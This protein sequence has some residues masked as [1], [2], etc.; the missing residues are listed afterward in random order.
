MGAG[1]SIDGMLDDL[2]TKGNSAFKAQ[3]YSEALVCYSAAID[4]AEKADCSDPNV[5]AALYSNRAAALL[6][7]HQNDAALADAQ[8]AIAYRPAW[9]KPYLRA[10]RALLALARVDAAREMLKKALAVAAALGTVG[11]A[12][13]NLLLRELDALNGATGSSFQT[14][15]D[16]QP[17]SAMVA[18]SP[19][20]LLTW[21]C[22]ES[23]CLGHGDMRDKSTP[24]AVSALRGRH[25]RDVGCGMLHT[26]V[27][28]SAGDVLAWGCDEQ[29]Q[30]G[31]ATTSGIQDD[32]SM[33]SAVLEPAPI[34]RLVAEGV[35]ATA[36]ACGAAHSVLL[37]ECANG[38]CVF[39]WGCGGHGQLGHGDFE[40]CVAPRR[41][42]LSVDGDDCALPIG[43]AA[44]IAHSALCCASDGGAR[45]F[46]MWGWNAQG[47]L[48]LGV[49][50]NVASPRRAQ[51]GE[52]GPQISSQR[53]ERASC[54]ACGGGHS[55]V[56]VDG[57]LFTAGSGACGQ[58]GHGQ[59]RDER[60]FRRVAFDDDEV[61]VGSVAFVACGEE[62]TCVV[63]STH[64]VFSMGLNNVGQLGLGLSMV[65]INR[66][67]PTLVQELDGKQTELL[68]CS[69]SQAVA[70]T[71]DGG[72]YAWGVA[73]NEVALANT[74]S[75]VVRAVPAAVGSLRRKKV[76][77][78]ECGRKHFAL[79][80]VSTYGPHCQL[81]WCGSK[82]NHRAALAHGVNDGADGV[83]ENGVAVRSATAGQL[84]RFQ[85]QCCDAFGT[86]CEHGGD[87]VV[88]T[89][90][91][92]TGIP[93]KTG[94]HG[95]M[96]T[97]EDHLDGTYSGTFT[98]TMVGVHELSVTVGE[99]NVS[100]SPLAIDVAA[101]V[102]HAPSCKIWWGKYEDQQSA[103]STE[104]TVNVLRATAGANMLFTVTLRDSF[105][106]EVCTTD[107]TVEAAVWQGEFDEDTATWTK[108][109]AGGSRVCDVGE[110][111][112]VVC[113]LQCPEI[114][115]TYSLALHVNG[116][117][118]K[119]S[120]WKLVICPAYAAP[121]RTKLQLCPL[122]S[123][124]VEDTVTNDKCGILCVQAGTERLLE[125]LLFD[126]F[127]NR[128]NSIAPDAPLTCFADNEDTV[129]TNVT[130]E[131]EFHENDS[132]S[133][134]ECYHE[135]TAALRWRQ[136]LTVHAVITGCVQLHVCL[137][138]HH[139]VGSPM[140]A[141]VFPA[142]ADALFSSLSLLDVELSTQDVKGAGCSGQ[143]VGELRLLPRDAFGNKVRLPPMSD[144]EATCA[145]QLVLKLER[146]DNVGVW[147]QVYTEVESAE[148][149][150]NID[151]DE[152]EG[153]LRYRYS[154]ELPSD[155]TLEP[156]EY[157]AF[158]KLNGQNMVG[159]PVYFTVSPPRALLEARQ[160]AAE[161][162]RA[163]A[164][165]RDAAFI[166]TTAARFAAT[167]V[168][169]AVYAAKRAEKVAEKQQARRTEQAML[170]E[171][172]KRKREL[173]AA[174]V[175]QRAKEAQVAEEEQQKR[176]AL[177]SKLRAEEA[178]RRRAQAALR[179][180]QECERERV[181]RE[182]CKPRA[183]RTGGGFVV[184]FANSSVP[185]QS[186][187]RRASLTRSDNKV[188]GS[189]QI[190]NDNDN[191][192]DIEM[193]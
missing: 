21:G 131:R 45:F 163:S 155:W 62:F 107:S 57:I 52:V 122:V 22:G 74:D 146:R 145:V 134:L 150:Q 36:V 84:C 175:A 109:S 113:H 58:L 124:A 37:A 156:I 71:A 14:T 154:H 24:R 142:K 40:Q 158:V 164:M 88:A 90:L 64:R 192:A 19:S 20:H 133:E 160:R 18:Q 48:G 63:T 56:V 111:A 81:L 69:Q 11:H 132:C 78:L 67:S 96:V 23:G 139:V 147:H 93:C 97:I 55:A 171:E 5:K 144:H 12:D 65:G 35:R 73:G 70:I 39:T 83:D 114:A 125:V 184:A 53:H 30:C 120:P 60:T 135:H 189:E 32:G 159:T 161:V 92:P 157:R 66:S 46:M 182:R 9:P 103:G 50:H 118:V 1:A 137:G 166:A 91:P 117:T 86:R 51:F 172:E 27:V 41:L 2:K 89:M 180:V 176:A 173:R 17:Q 47:Q 7:S 102:V 148:E 170:L 129:I 105:R 82:M 34:P 44:G 140:P 167:A 112:V 115:C 110:G 123:P 186:G 169:R 141:E 25:I 121:S 29:G 49:D 8:R 151:E 68:S 193:C 116:A 119:S 3:D 61:N 33:K 72:I 31:G 181:R 76:L 152:S 106:N 179:K 87:A 143:R 165:A 104:D 100:G 101:N 98:P 99:L 162:D 136:Q 188:E 149:M 80:T 75:S 42:Q 108:V 185:L 13:R 79:V 127:G 38:G 190:Q 153:F 128:T 16:A 4:A 85:V 59:C 178:T 191:D 138:E 26:V 54:I 43:V 95:A 177:M 183:R 77:R 126:E 174:E 130:A 94:D 10:A 6:A 28:T 168:E 187:D 15:G